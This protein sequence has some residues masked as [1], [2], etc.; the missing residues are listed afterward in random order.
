MKVVTP[1]DKEEADTVW[2]LDMMKQLGVS[3]HNM[4]SCSVTSWGDLLFVNTSNG[5]HDDHKTIPA[6]EAPSFLCMNKH[7][8]E[9][10]WSD[11]RPGG[12]I[13][14]G[15]WSSP[16]V[17]II[18]GVPQVIFGG[19]DGW[20]YG[21][22]ADQ[23]QGWQG[24]AAV[25][26]RHQREGRACSN[27]AARGTKNDIIATPVVYDD[28]VYFATGQDPEHG[29]GKGIFW[30]IDP[31]KRGDLSESLAVKR[32]RPDKPI[33]PNACNRSMEEDGERVDSQSELR[34]G[35][36]AHRRRLEQA[37][38]RSMISWRRF[39]RGIGTAAIKDDLFFVADFAGMFLCI[40]AQTGKVH[41]GHDMLA[42]SWGSALIAG[43]KVFAGDED[44]DI[45]IFN[46]SADPKKAMI[47]IEGEEKPYP[48]NAKRP[49]PES[50]PEVTNMANSVHSSPII[51][52]GVLWIANRD[53]LFAIELGAKPITE[54][55]VSAAK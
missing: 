24:G 41:W 53:H 14:H 52:N 42:A 4:C 19:G 49:D 15:Q 16:A 43:D 45:A 8:G 11:N 30:C 40:D 28:K 33:P 22:K 39:H 5:V 29:E 6:P 54:N 9:I 51:A 32:G 27:W 31:T 50:N 7:T 3:Q 1:A 21:F 10:Y 35:V 38:A 17:A 18:E 12:N 47:E 55:A 46:H 48:I 2:S 23:R 26:V 25:E 36:E 13:L 34:R 20:V 44:G 37:M